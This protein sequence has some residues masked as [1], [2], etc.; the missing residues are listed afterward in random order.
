MKHFLLSFFLTLYV[1]A[2]VFTVCLICGCTV[3]PSTKPSQHGF[4]TH[5]AINGGQVFPIDDA[6]T[7]EVGSVRFI[8]PLGEITLTGAQCIYQK[9]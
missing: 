6:A 2:I 4:C 3:K 8:S 1:I 5:P 9:N 7:F